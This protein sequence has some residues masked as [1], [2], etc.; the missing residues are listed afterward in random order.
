M[1]QK[2]KFLKRLLGEIGYYNKSSNEVSF[3]CPFCSHHKPKFYVNLE[4]D[5]YNCYYSKCKASGIGLY[6][7]IKKVGTAE[8]LAL[9]NSEFRARNIKEKEV[10]NYDKLYL[11]KEFIS[12]SSL[13]DS[14]IVERLR[15]Y[16]HNRGLTPKDILRNKIG[17]CV[18]GRFD[19][20]IVFPSFDK[21]GEVNYFTAKDIDRN[22]Y[23]L[24]KTQKG[25]KNSIIINELNIDF[26]KPIFIVEGMIDAILSGMNNVAPLFGS[27]LS[28]NSKLFREI[29]KNRT[30]VFLA[31]D[32]DAEE[33]T[34]EIAE[35]FIKYCVSV[36]N[37]NVKPYNDIGEMK[38]DKFAEAYEN[39][40][41]LQ[42][43]DILKGRMRMKC[44]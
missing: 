31:L 7:I 18:G 34:L 5:L 11:P 8:D 19:G 12:L 25:Y 39:A 1:Y 42:E 28:I 26:S 10:K 24:P 38:Q 37:V 3:Y 30:N 27:S 15:N 23:F 36:Y 33:K 2:L 41:I 29:V 44:H 22:M 43:M 16:L 4:K 17:T 21:Y 9:Y 6:N 14:F 35:K 32:A 13:T 40:T 20:M